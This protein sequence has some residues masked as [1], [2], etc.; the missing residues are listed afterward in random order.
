MPGVE[1]LHVESVHELEM[2]DRLAARADRSV[3]VLLRV[4]LPVP[5]HLLGGS[6]LSMGGRPT[7]FGLEPQA[8]LEWLARHA[9][10]LH[11]HITVAGVHTHLASGLAAEP[12][13]AVA[14]QVLSWATTVFGWRGLPLREV[15]L[16]GGMAVDYADPETLFDWAA[17]G[18]GLARLTARHPE[19]TL[20]IE[21]GRALTAYSGWYATDVLDVKSSQDEEFAVLRGGTHHLRTPAA[22]SHDQPASV[23]AMRDWPHPWPRPSAHSSEVHLVG[24][25]C[26]PKDVLARLSRSHT[27]SPPATGWRSRWPARTH[28]TSRTARASLCTPTRPTRAGRPQPSRFEPD[29]L[30]QAPRLP[31]PLTSTPT[32]FE[33]QAPRRRLRR[34]P[35]HVG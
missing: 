25:L 8:A 3:T 1:R 22:K 12:L 35:R 26:T 33:Q 28:G 30:V 27:D 24:Q 34:A 23:L 29:P 2:L 16:G 15:N 6:A 14:E 21:P 10:G 4:N 9:E 17:Y 11:P 32:S 18:D 20:R 31:P 7:P 5:A 19:P 13:V